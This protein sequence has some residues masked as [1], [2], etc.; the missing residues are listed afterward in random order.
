MA[1]ADVVNSVYRITRKEI[2]ISPAACALIGVFGF[3]LATAAGAFIRIPLPFTPVPLTLQTFFVLLSGAILGR[4]LGILSQAGYVI[5]GL[6]G[7]PIFAGAH[8][9]GAYFLGPTGGY[10]VGFAAASYV[11]GRILKGR[12]PANLLKITFAMAAGSAV[13]YLFGAAWLAYILKISFEKAMLLG[14]LPFL[15]GDIV[16]AAVAVAL[17][18]PIEKRMKDVFP[19]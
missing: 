2:V 11:V 8:A 19:A 13:I 17:Y 1:Y 15:P 16:K 18:K 5:V 14:V 9:G 6:I 3:I 12:R 4:R 10:L 7:L